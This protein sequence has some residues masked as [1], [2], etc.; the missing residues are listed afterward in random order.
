MPRQQQLQLSAGVAEAFAGAAGAEADGRHARALPQ[1][2]AREPLAA[3]LAAAAAAGRASVALP[4]AASLGPLHDSFAPFALHGAGGLLETV[5]EAGESPYQSPYMARSTP[6]AGTASSA[7]STV[8]PDA[9]SPLTPASAFA[10]G[11]SPLVGSASQWATPGG[12]TLQQI[13]EQQLS[14]GASPGGLSAA[15]TPGLGSAARLSGAPTPALSY[16]E[17]L[18]PASAGLRSPLSAAGTPTPDLGLS[19][20]GWGGAS[21]L[22][23]AQ[24]LAGAPTPRE[25]GLSGAY[26]IRRFRYWEAG[27]WGAACAVL[28]GGA[29]WLAAWLSTLAPPSLV[30]PSIQ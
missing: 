28:Y 1:P 10:A 25:L 7:A 18:S 14:P 24:Q 8:M 11:G 20:E 17:G 12:T 4:G 21:P 15:P 16:R 26:E 9:A 3:R 2:P 5:P 13:L 23:D 22:L 27:A 29:G 30:P 6:G 19:G